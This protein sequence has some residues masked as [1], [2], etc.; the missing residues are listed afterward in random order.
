MKFDEYAKTWDT[1]AMI[2][3][4]KNIAEKI[5]SCIE[6][7]EDLTAMEFGCATGLISF[8]L[9]EVFKEIVLID[10]S[11][12]MIN[13]VKEKIAYYDNKNIEALC[14]D[15]TK[16]DYLDKKF[17]VIYTSMALHHVKDIKKLINMFYELLNKDGKLCIIDLDKEDGSFH[18]NGKEFD[19]HNGFEHSNIVKVLAENKF[20][21][22][23]IETF[24]NIKK[25]MNAN[26]LDKKPTYSLFCAVGKKVD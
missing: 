12:E 3:R 8:N 19:G 14:L 11:A 7:K 25:I 23:E 21:D 18:E 15:L 4:S 24:C 16:N 26:N 17:D 9:S 1:E 20:M 6:Y 22:I 2:E 13:V 5:K 10:S